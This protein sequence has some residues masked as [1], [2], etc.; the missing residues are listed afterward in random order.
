MNIVISVFSE[1]AYKEIV[2]PSINNTDYSVSLGKN[3]FQISEDIVL[4]F[5]VIEH[6]WRILSDSAYTLRQSNNEVNEID[7]S[8]GAQFEII[9]ADGAIIGVTV[10]YKSAG[11]LK[12]NKYF[13]KNDCITIGSSEKNDIVCK[14]SFISHTH[15][16]IAFYHN[17]WVIE[18]LSQN[19]VFLNS[20]RVKISSVLKYGDMINIIGLKIVFLGKIIAVSDEEGVNV[21]LDTKLL[22]P[23]AEEAAKSLNGEKKKKIA[24]KTYFNRAPRILKEFYE[25][26]TNI[27]APPAP[28]EEEE[29]SLLSTIGP[30][31]TMAIPMLL[32]CMLMIY[33]S[34][35][36]GSAV[37]PFMFMGLITAVSSAILGAVWG[38]IN[39]KKAS[40]KAEEAEKK[41]FDAFSEYLMKMTEKIKNMNTYNKEILHELYPSAEECT[42]FT[43]KNKNLWNRNYTHRDFLSHRIGIGDLPFQAEINIPQEKFTLINDSLADKP[44]E[45]KETYST[46]KSVPVCL[47]LME[48]K[49]I[50]IVG[51]RNKNGAYQIVKALS[52]QIA[53][54]NCYTDVKLA[55]LFRDESRRKDVE[56]SKWLPHCWSED[57]KTRYCAFSQ[58]EV[59]DICYELTKTF[60]IRDEAAK[61]RHNSSNGGFRPHYVIFVEDIAL[62]EGEPLAKYIFDEEA[63]YG[64][65]AVL[66]A[67]NYEDLPNS[68]KCIVYNDGTYTGIYTPNTLSGLGNKLLVDTV[69][70]ESLEKLARTLSKIEISEVATNGEIPNSLSFLDM[71]KVDRVEDLNVIERWKKNR[72]YENM[73]SLIGQK[74]GGADCYLDIH[75]KYHGPHGLVAGTTGSGKSETLQTYILS[76]AINY[77]PDDVGF[78]LVDFKGGGMANLFTD[79]P[80]TL[81]QISN[82]SGAQI[83][84]AMVSIKSENLRRQRIFS[85]NGVNNINAYTRL[86]KNNEA[87]VTLPH[88]FIIIDEFAEMKREEPEFMTELISVAQVGRSLGV[89]L[90]LATQKPGGVVD[91]N[92]RSNS[93]FKLCLRVQDKQDS[94]EMLGKPDAAYLSQAGRCYLQVGNDEIFELFQSGWSGATYSGDGNDHQNFV[95]MISTTGKTVLNGNKSAQKHKEEIRIRWLSAFADCISAAAEECGVDLIN[96]SFNPIGNSVFIEKIFALLD[97][98]E[99]DYPYSAFNVKCTQ[100]FISLLRTYGKEKI[101]TII[102]EAKKHNQQL[103]EPKEITQLD[104][105]ID[106]LCDVAEK[107]NY[108]HG[109]PLWLPMLPEHFCLDSMEAFRIGSFAELQKWNN[110]GWSLFAPVGMYDDP[111]NQAQMP[112]FVDFGENGHLAVCGNVTSGKS[113]FLQTLLYSL[114]NRYSPEQLNMY[115][116]DFSNHM[117]QAFETY[118]HTGAVIHENEEEKTDKFFYMLSQMLIE[119]KKNIGGG[120]FGQFVNANGH[121]FPAVVIAIDN[122]S[123]FR[124]KTDDKYEQIIWELSRDGASFGLY[125]AISAGG[126]GSV[127]IQNKIGE[128]IRNVIA[129]DLGDKIKFSEVLKVMHLNVLPAGNIKGRGLAP[130]GDSFLEFQTALAVEAED[131]YSRSQT[132]SEIGEKMKAEYKGK[133]AKKIPEIPEKPTWTDINSNEEYRELIAQKEL[134]PFAYVKE[135]ASI[136]SVDL[137]ETFCYLIQGKSRTGRTD[138]LKVLM[139]SAHEKE[140]EICVFEPNGSQFKRIC[141]KLGAEHLTTPKEIFDYCLEFT[142]IFKSR[143]KIK[144]DMLEDG[145][146]ESEIFDRMSE[147]KPIMIFV[148]SLSD[149]L[150]MIYSLQE[151]CG[152]MNGFFENIFEKGRLHN[153]YFFFD[154]NIEYAMTMLGKKAYGLITGYKTGVQLGGLSGQKVFDTSSM[155]FAEQNK[156]YRP[157]IG[158]AFGN[159]GGEKIVIPSSK[160]I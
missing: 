137:S 64:L 152:T 23:S 14:A 121:L 138:L 63:E 50:G 113:T 104:A 97:Q 52:S 107:Y 125:L 100:N 4:K 43:R 84:R 136:Y 115:I 28:K 77:S 21:K 126:F 139:A 56:F 151:D 61:E 59:S 9:G 156:T 44:K 33:S 145:A 3:I 95:R 76:L 38:T 157:G 24:A 29:K 65:T 143:N 68:C 130:Y 48:N 79:L 42:S 45:I 37:T 11:V 74:A 54:S 103:P 25:E 153:I 160:G 142:K 22:L 30:S 6:K 118:P 5:D 35:S 129:L 112:V 36:S 96:Q 16:R 127:E 124:E 32:G 80:H 62:L 2:L 132:I 75:E 154:S 83:R 26:P 73:R 10:A 134:L 53:V 99:I 47:D 1:K 110:F 116:L 31:F 51:G 58:D 86:L 120:N 66:L 94:S 140:A 70:D 60:R 7:L 72:T 71:Y 146:E 92:I 128:N 8:D 88:L 131:D 19:G 18:D 158:H 12:T 87:T 98:L 81:G 101:E 15:A 106:H 147:E 133:I 117:L 123:N 91:D 111:E 13:L 39:F 105:V 46:L 148:T 155:P 90:I 82:L 69:S 89:H 85:E 102:E 149:F 20:A 109:A 159:L 122:Y 57:K 27:E 135:T 78:L 119:R 49:I 150:S 108:K 93:K 40:K 17:E 114:A 144:F 41:R 141:E 34:R 55:Y 67:Q